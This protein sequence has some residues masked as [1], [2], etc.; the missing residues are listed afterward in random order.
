MATEM[1]DFL[2]A[3][4]KARF[5]V[6]I[7][8][9]TGSGKTTLLNALSRF[10]PGSER[11]VTIEDTAELELQQPHVAK[12]EAQP[13]DLDG[14]GG[15]TIRDL[16]RNAL[17]MRPDRIIVG[18][19]RGGE[20]LEMMQAM[21]TGHDGSMTTIHANSTR[22]ALARVELMVGLAGVEIPVG[23]I[24]KLIASS[25]S[26]VVQVARLPGGKRRVVT[27]SEIIGLEGDIVSMHD[28]FIFA[29]TGTN[30]DHGAEGYF[31]ATGIRPALLNKLNVRGAN[32]PSEWFIE[33]RLPPPRGRGVNR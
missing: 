8:G 11:L 7:S 23:A 17:R 13:A 9:G 24:R 10:V 22:E 29:Q 12:M 3:C 27:I 33:R 20:A 25:I 21:N 18:E 15:V 32:V 4:V 14:E 26:L 19:C 1:L 30:L 6:I 28:L 16:V 31:R 5:N 2:A